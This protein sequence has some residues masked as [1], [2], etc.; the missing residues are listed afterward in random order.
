[1]ALLTKTCSILGTTNSD[2]ELETLASAFDA[3]QQV[4]VDDGYSLVGNFQMSL[5]DDGA[6]GKTTTFA[7]TLQKVAVAVE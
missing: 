6:G 7:Q 3:K 4:L 5:S 1:M 2:L